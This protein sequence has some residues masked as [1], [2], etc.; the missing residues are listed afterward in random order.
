MKILF[1]L[2]LPPPVHGAAIVGQ[3]IKDSPAINE[4]FIC[5]YINLGISASIDEIGKNGFIK[6]FRYFSLLWQVVVQLITFRPQLCYLTITAKG[7]G[8]YKDA[9]VVLLAKLSGAKLVYHFHNKGVN[10]RQ[11][12]F[13][14]NLLYRFVFKN[15][16]VILLSKF[17]YPD[18][19]QYV[20]EE[21]VHYCPNGVPS[22]GFRVP[23]SEFGVTGSDTRNAKRKTLNILFLSN[24]I[25]SKG[26]FVLLEACKVLQSKQLN[27]HCTFVGGIGDISEP[28]FQFKVRQLGLENVV[29]YAGKKYKIEKEAKFAKADIF[30]HPT[31]NDCFPLVLLEAM[32]HSL[33]IVSTFEGAICEIVED[34]VTGFLVTRK[35]SNALAEK[36]EILIN[37]P[38][39]RQQMGKAGR[40]KY[41]QEFTLP[42]FENRLRGILN[43]ILESVVVQGVDC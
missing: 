40:A 37:N 27:F 31:S 35:D 3:T 24:L 20:K 19:Q 29:T 4:T 12:K 18:I 10:T 26:V 5:R 39:L 17:L 43:T 30:V 33:P 1:I 36:L 2:H 23:G 15:V 41:E 11:H 32:Q 34:G 9:M 25:E 28:Q 42:I 6:V 21:R 22:S 16:D 14:D 13:F 38:Q 7:S 8:F